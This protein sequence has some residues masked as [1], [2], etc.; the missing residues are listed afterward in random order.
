MDESA[1]CDNYV[2]ID[3]A[4]HFLLA[5]RSSLRILETL[6]VAFAQRM[7]FVYSLLAIEDPL[8]VLKIDW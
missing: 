6:S 8:I 3:T 2:C 5:Q 1:C 4:K 7:Q